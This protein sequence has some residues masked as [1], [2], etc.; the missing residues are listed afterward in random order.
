LVLE[1]K[2]N[3]GEAESYYKRA[4]EADPKDAVAL[5]SYAVFLEGKGNTEEA[6]SY[7][8]RAIEA[9]PKDAVALRN[10]ALVRERKG[11]TEEA[12]NY[13]KKAIEADPKY[14]LA[15]VCCANLLERKGHTEEA[16]TFFNRAID[17]N[18]KDGNDEANRAHLFFR[19]KQMDL[20]FEQL[21][22][23]E[24]HKLQTKE[25]KM[26]MLFY[27]LA[28]DPE[29]WPVRLKDM[30]DLLAD[31]ARSPDWPLDNHAENAKSLEHPN[32]ELLL[33]IANVAS[34]GAPLSSLESFDQWP[35]PAE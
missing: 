21:K 11:N 35:K 33:A 3:T 30:R 5:N 8:K 7:Y 12:E 1:R 29:A 24:S 34:K 16:E 17:V 15:L 22:K 25:A 18:P 28:Y 10:Y 13:Y 9:D 31:G 19:K 27:R 32:V 23:A 2:G 4:I 14:A 20:A 26:E 6:E